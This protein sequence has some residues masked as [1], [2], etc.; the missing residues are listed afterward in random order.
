MSKNNQVA[1]ATDEQIANYKAI[2]NNS[3]IVNGAIKSF[4]VFDKNSDDVKKDTTLKALFNSVINGE[5]QI[6]ELS[7]DHKVLIFVEGVSHGIRLNAK[8]FASVCLDSRVKSD[9]LLDRTFRGQILTQKAGDTFVSIDKDGNTS[10]GTVKTGTSQIVGEY[11]LMQSA[12]A[13]AMATAMSTLT[14]E[15]RYRIA[16]GL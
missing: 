12:R 9:T 2:R 11:N 1:I 13:T 16:C 6:T 8:S 7:D 15:E 5:K 4:I 14:A 10:L 3:P